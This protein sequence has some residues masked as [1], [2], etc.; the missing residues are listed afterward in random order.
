VLGVAAPLLFFGTKKKKRSLGSSLGGV[1]AS[2]YGRARTCMHACMEQS[3][4]GQNGAMARR[5]PRNPSNAE[6][7]M[8]NRI[9]SLLFFL[10]FAILLHRG[11]W[12]AA[13]R[14]Y[15]HGQIGRKEEQ[16]KTK[17]NRAK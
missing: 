5:S 1:L 12:A 17:K 3:S 10:F 6:N 8:P 14:S 2:L 15:V 11:P 16:T 13:R 9:A 4:T 7:A